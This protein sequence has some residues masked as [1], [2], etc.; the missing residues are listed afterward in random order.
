M[1]AKASFPLRVPADIKS[2]IKKQAALNGSSQ[3]SE[4]IRALRAA[5]ARDSGGS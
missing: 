4:V 1:A 5:M 2:W 3:N